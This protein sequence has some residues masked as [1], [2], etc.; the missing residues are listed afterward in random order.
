MTKGYHAMDRYEENM[1]L[2]KMGFPELYE[3]I[4]TE[5]KGGRPLEEDVAAVD[6]METQTDVAALL[7]QTAGGDVVRL[8]S[9]YDPEHEAAVWADGREGLDK[10]VLLVFGLG[11]GVF[12]R[13]ILRRKKAE[14]RV[15]IYEPSV[16]VFLFVLRRFDLRFCFQDPNVRLIVEGVNENLF[17]AVMEVL[18]TFENYEDYQFVLCPK[19]QE[20]FPKSR[21]KFVSLF[22]SEGIGWL[23]TYR[24]V[25]RKRLYISPYNQLHNLKFLAENTVVPHLKGIFPK[26]VP[27]LL[28]GAGPS[29]REEIEVLRKVRDRV[30]LFAA[31]SALPFL[32]KNNVIPDAFVC[33][34]ADKPMH[35]FEDERCR[36]VPAFVKVDS[37]HFL[38][39]IHQSYKI[40]GYDMGFMERFYEEYGVERSQYR[41]GA[42]GMTSLFSICD[43]IGVQTVIFVGQD[44][45]FGEEKTTHVGGRNEGYRENGIFLCENNQGETV[46][47]RV[48]WS[49]FIQWYGN[50]IED[51]GMR[52]VINTSQKGAKI[53][54]TEVMSLEEAVERYGKE[55][56]EFKEVLKQAACTFSHSGRRFELVKF[57]ERCL[58]ELTEIEQITNRNP[59][60]EERE[61]FMIYGLLKKYEI[62]DEEEDFVRSQAGGITKLREYLEKLKEGEEQ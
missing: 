53:R 48:D 58:G 36:A 2:M 16:N 43:E 12:A 47:S 60:S 5:T 35:F 8:N 20:L 6:V 50:A 33:I 9:A 4:T 14:T 15:V 62:A 3:K 24:N 42:N 45:C 26:E 7:V 59:H 55:H 44:M 25:E 23:Q 61:T 1:R 28:V 49:R 52:H 57:Y 18:L 13:E 27:V 40:F 54:G 56:I 22:A 46:Q 17:G 39:D 19:M 11:N 10:K 30:F 21:Q 41:Y 34:E 38:L 29:L 32:M 31:D 51:C 37:T